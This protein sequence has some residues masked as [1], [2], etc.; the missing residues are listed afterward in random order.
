MD[1]LSLPDPQSSIPNPQSATLDPQSSTFTPA[2]RSLWARWTGLLNRREYGTSLALFRIGC[3]LAV[4]CSV[5]SALLH[6]VAGAVWL[7][8][9]DGGYRQWGNPLWL[10]GLAGGESAAQRH[11]EY[12][13]VGLGPWLF[14]LLGGVSPATLWAMVGVV[15]VSALMLI[16]GLGGRIT[17]FVL[18][19]AYI[20]V[21]GIND[22]IWGGDDQLIGNA[23][24][25][26]VLG[27]AT[28][29]LSLD[30]RLRTGCWRS[31]T[32][33]AAWPRYLAI[34]QLVLVYF[35][36]AMQKVS[37]YWTPAGEYSALYYILQ[38]PTW[39]RWD[40]S[41]LAWV[42]PLTQVATALT[43]CWELSS[44]LLLLALWYRSTPER[45][46]WL[47]TLFNAI[48]FR[49]LYV[50]VGLGMHL[51]IWILM[52]VGPFS[53]ITL[54]FYF[55]LY[56]PEEWRTT[57]NRVR[58]WWTKTARTEA[59]PGVALETV[60]PA[61]A[62]AAS[63]RRWLD[64]L[65]YAFVTLHVVAITLMA[66]PSPEGAMDRADWEIPSAQAEFIGWADRLTDW[67]FTVT[68]AE[69]KDILWKTAQDYMGVRKWVLAPFAP[70]YDLCGTRQGWRMFVGPD[71]TPRRLY[72]E[73]RENRR[74]RP[75]YV[76]RDPDHNWLGFQLNH[77]HLRTAVHDMG[78][79]KK[80][81][82]LGQFAQWVAERAARDFPRADQLRLRLK[83]FEIPTPEEVRAGRRHEGHWVA[84]H[85][86]KL[87]PF[88]D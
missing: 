26:L 12:F 61:P 36:T 58:G 51:G 74:W 39:Q 8:Q 64:R 75:V 17:T 83:E 72:I 27:R 71:T 13:K 23:L 55:C 33:V 49:R 73:V 63:R 56:R 79:Y 9:A 30:C 32:L 62:L 15:M 21:S 45:R 76:A 35:T 19:Q 66:V 22:Q 41:W 69:L 48:N 5:G 20:A 42:F 59:P 60:A 1:R 24:W 85:V 28:A 34:Y 82:E 53:W 4:F 44:P 3:G 43:W 14:G 11:F 78:L 40:M 70:Y 16:V 52:G 50:L 10:F 7:D 37:I 84:R 88:R 57:W 54:S 6:G 38:E 87:A 68:P 65:V 86:V 31:D 47:R 81:K 80:G 77:E 46:G 18:L 67:G 25:L 29:T 2:R